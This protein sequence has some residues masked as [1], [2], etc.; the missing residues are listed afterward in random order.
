[1]N[2]NSIV[3]KP[4]AG[5]EQ[6]ILCPME[7][8]EGC[9]LLCAFWLGYYLVFYGLRKRAAACGKL[10]NKGRGEVFHKFHRTFLNVFR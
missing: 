4:R 5:W 7:S 2:L 9:V 1:M 8:R 10:T 6:Q 3:T